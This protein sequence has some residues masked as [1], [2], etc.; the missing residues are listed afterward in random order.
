MLGLRA[1]R[2]HLGFVMLGVRLRTGI[3]YIR[4]CILPLLSSSSSLFIS[5]S[6]IYLEPK[7]WAL[8]PSELTSALRALEYEYPPV[9]SSPTP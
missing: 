2:S 1:P 9:G 3:C 7:L 5:T 8:P 4:A 6:C